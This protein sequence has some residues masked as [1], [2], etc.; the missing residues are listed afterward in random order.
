MKDIARWLPQLR[1]CAVRLMIT[2]AA[3]AVVVV[4]VVVVGGGGGLMFALSFRVF[5]LLDPI[6]MFPFFDRSAFAWSRFLP[7]LRN[8]VKRRR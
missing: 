3:A 6:M 8:R 7:K 2:T 4:V 1:H 5:F